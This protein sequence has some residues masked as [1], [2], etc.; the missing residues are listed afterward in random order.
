MQQYTIMRSQGVN[1]DILGN[2]F[3]RFEKEET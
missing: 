1:P 3:K 2:M